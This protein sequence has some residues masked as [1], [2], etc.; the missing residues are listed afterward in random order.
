MHPCVTP[1]KIKLV[2]A[3][4][5]PLQTE[6][7]IALAIDRVGKHDFIIAPQLKVQIILWSDFMEKFN[8]R[9][10]YQKRIIS[11][12]KKS[13]PMRFAQAERIPAVRSVVEIADMPP[14]L[15]GLED[16]P[17]FRDELGHCTVGEPLR[18]N[19]N[20]PAI[21]QKAY[22]QPLVKRKVVEEEVEKMLAAGIIEPSQSSWASPITLVGKPDGSVRF[23]VDYRR[24]NAI[25]EPDCYPLPNITELLDLLQGSKIF[26]TMDLRSGYHQVDLHPDDIPK[27][28]FICHA[29]LFQFRRL[30]FGLVN[31]PSQFQRLMN[32]VLSKFLNKCVLVYID[33]IVVFS[34]TEEEH[35][36]QLAEVL[37]T[38]HEAGLTVKLKKCS[39][40]QKAVKLLGY[41]VSDEG[42]APQESKVAA[43]QGMAPPEDV[44]ALRRILGIHHAELCPS[45]RTPAE[46]D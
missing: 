15:H 13:F 33:D 38:L 39:F 20:G 29:G 46:I 17:V 19:T 6:G 5:A 16:H 7:R 27:S 8:A 35:R 30:S 11:L 1:N 41:N 32:K 28:A 22:R 23:C 9:V 42:I 43:I 3:S 34:K 21:K 36:Q 12:P 44:R 18:I 4:G 25:T 24:V 2:T 10:D 37:D 26:S 14:F 40:G 45:R 31:A